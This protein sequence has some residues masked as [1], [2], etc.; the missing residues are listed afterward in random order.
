MGVWPFHGPWARGGCCV[1]VVACAVAKRS[2]A[3]ARA[4]ACLIHVLFLSMRCSLGLCG[5]HDSAGRELRRAVRVFVFIRKA[6]FAPAARSRPPFIPHAASPTAVVRH[7]SDAAHY[8][9]A[10]TSNRTG[11]RWRS[12]RSSCTHTRHPPAAH[13]CSRRRLR[14]VYCMHEGDVP[15]CT[16]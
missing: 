14:S 15:S 2:A 8:G 13:F 11:S 1:A 6:L 16:V 10:R 3:S 9:G 12:R 7:P 4:L 5:P